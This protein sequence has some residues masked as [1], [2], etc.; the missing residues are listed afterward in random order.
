MT[1]PIS[2]FLASTLA[3][4]AQELPDILG[5]PP[6]KTPEEWIS[7]QRQAT[8]E[9]FRK[10][11]YGR[12]PV[13]RPEKLTF[14]TV[15]ETAGALDGSATRRIVNI[16]FSG[17]GGEGVM[18]LILFIPEHVKKPAP[19]FLLICNRPA[20]SIDPTRKTRSPFW[21][22]EEIVARGYVAAAFENSDIDPDNDDGFKDGVHGI[23]DPKGVKRPG[24]AWGTIAAWAWG[25]SRAMDYFETANDI[26]QDRIAVIGHSRG[27]K[28]S[29]WAGAEDERFGMVISNNSGCTGAALA[30]RKQG[31]RIAD[32][33]KNFPHWFCGNYKAFNEKEDDLPI[34]QHQL[35]ALIAPR[36]VYIA[37][38]KDDDWADPEGE[39]LAGYHATPVYKLFGLEGIHTDEMPPVDEPLAPS[40]IGY[41]IRT[42]KH[43]LTLY[44][45]ERYMD[46]A[47]RH[48]RAGK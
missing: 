31:E 23:Y 13:G 3:L 8:L 26:D 7:K 11:V 46:F 43:D 16:R 17:E 5:S 28:T 34:D 18:K 15:E 41:H 37:S 24:D 4:S 32:I 30:R 40:H 21:P 1:H 14:E 6:A 19:G 44:D 33:N 12:A 20:E 48:F 10:H 9:L 36:P 47:D 22:A 35:I 42:G 27:G 39:F 29:L 2:L 45:W 38:A 25:A